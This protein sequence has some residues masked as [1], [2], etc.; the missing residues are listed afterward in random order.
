RALPVAVGGALQKQQRAEEGAIHVSA[1]A[2]VDA[3]HAHAVGETLFGKSANRQ[4]M[5]DRGP[6]LHL[7]VE[8]LAAP[9]ETNGAL[10]CRHGA[11][12]V[13]S[14]ASF[15]AVIPAPARKSKSL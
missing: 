9:E 15:T 12:R 14:A 2:Q 6:A 8:R 10:R 1:T 13:C 11:S 4:A 3:E 7:K 5:G